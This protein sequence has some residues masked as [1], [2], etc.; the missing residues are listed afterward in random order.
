MRFDDDNLCV[1]VNMPVSDNN[2]NNR[3]Y[4]HTY[5]YFDSDGTTTTNKMIVMKDFN[6]LLP[7]GNVMPGFGLGTWKSDPGVVGGAVHTAIVDLGYRHIDCAAIYGNEKEIGKTFNSILTSFDDDNGSN[8]SARIKRDDLFVTSKLWNTEHAHDDV[9]PALRRTL[10]D[11]QLDYLDLYL[12]HWPVA[13][14]AASASESDDK[15]FGEMI[16][17]EERPIIDT[18]RA[19]E[20]CVKKGLVKD[21][22]VSNFS[23]K[24]L[25]DLCSQA[26]I[27]P[28]VNQVELHPYLQM[29]DLF[30]YCNEEGIHL[31]AYS[32]LGSN[33]R[34]EMLKGAN[35]KKIMN[36]PTIIEIATKH[37]MTPAQVLIRWAL[38]RG[39]SCIPKSVS[40][41]RL[42][43]NIMAAAAPN[44]S[45]SSSSSFHLTED[46]MASIAKL[47]IGQ[48][49]VD[50]SFWCGEGSPYTLENLW[51]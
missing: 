34:P 30:D 33:D 48:R 3:P 12:I 25:Q 18:W 19:M 8:S 22:G 32:P 26:N 31:T 39:T 14:K 23:K 5:H 38:Q 16:S 11:L 6:T 15:P 40:R 44:T 46:D 13:T 21:I 24:K 28:A 7:S 2:N 10:E 9:E 4:H 17:L 27:K 29:N 1:I 41:E 42:Q 50:G 51:D 45:S 47:D 37:N 20:V 35:E 36:D 49:Y 43:Q